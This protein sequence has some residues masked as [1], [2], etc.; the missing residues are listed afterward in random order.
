VAA[1][2]WHYIK[3][4]ESP[5]STCCLWRMPAQQCLLQQDAYLKGVTGKQRV[6]FQR[7]HMQAEGNN[8]LLTSSRQC[9]RDKFTGN[10]DRTRASNLQRDDQMRV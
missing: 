7:Q 6:C 3:Q 4:A 8:P 2:K 1:V 9:G 5:G 10:N